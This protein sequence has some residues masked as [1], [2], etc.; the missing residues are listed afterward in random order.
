MRKLLMLAATL[1][2]TAALVACDKGNSDNNGN[3]PNY[4]VAPNYYQN[5]VCVNPNG[6]V[7]SQN[8]TFYDANYN[9]GGSYGSGNLRITNAG[10]YKEFLERSLGVCN[11]ATWSYGIAGCDAWASGY[12]LMK[13][14][15]SNINTN[16]VTLAF[17]AWPQTGVINGG[18]NI[19]VGT[20][21]PYQN[22]LTL[23]NSVL[24]VVNNYQGFEVR[25]SINL[26]L[27]QVIVANGKLQD[28]S[29]NFQLAYGNSATKTGQV[30][31]TG[32]L[33]RSASGY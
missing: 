16:Q 33:T 8:A 3:M 19:G 14:Q 11:R 6:G 13:L 24:S 25:R 5:G 26:G 17:Q 4:C 31:A 32:T 30:F 9:M 15:A 18:I 12:L 28:G 29:I 7:V 20:G 10:V 23:N 2:S 1:L 22:P 27:I 21:I